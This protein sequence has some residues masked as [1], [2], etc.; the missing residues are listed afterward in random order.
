LDWR[1]LLLAVEVLSPS[2]A[3]TD[4]QRKRRI[5]QDV[6]IPE[7]WIVDLDSR[8][9][10]RWRPTDKRPEV[11]SDPFTWEPQPNVPPLTIDPVSLFR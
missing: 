2:T 9:V 6:G 5:Y 4:R 7:Y 8:V 10:E 1:S 3:R 11:L